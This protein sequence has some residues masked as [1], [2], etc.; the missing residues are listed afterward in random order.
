MQ[1][2][3]N[4]LAPFILFGIAIVAFVFGIMLLA[5]LFFFGALI[6]LILFMISWIRNRFFP[7]K[8]VAKQV[9][10]GRIIDS[11]DWKKL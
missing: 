6:G 9:K 10:S 11:D 4:Q 5:Y 7:P 1:R 2:L 8:G 3:L